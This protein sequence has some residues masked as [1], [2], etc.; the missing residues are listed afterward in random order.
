MNPHG[1]HT[2]KPRKKWDTPTDLPLSLQQHSESDYYSDS[3]ESYSS[4]TSSP[5]I[6]VEILQKLNKLSPDQTSLLLHY[7]KHLSTS[8]H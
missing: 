5:P 8:S 7:I 1:T 4:E 2:K 6:L 3:F